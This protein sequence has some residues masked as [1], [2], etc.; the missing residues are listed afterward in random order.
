MSYTKEL[1]ADRKVRLLKMQAIVGDG[2]RSISAAE[3]TEFDR[4][5]GEI[6]SLDVK[7][8]HAKDN[9]P[10]GDYGGKRKRITVDDERFT[11]YLRG[12]TG[13]PEYRAALDGNSMSTAPNSGGVSAGATGYDA[14]YMVPQGFWNQL[15]IALKAYGGLSSSF[16]QVETQTGNPMPWPS[17]DP[18]AISGKYLTEVNQL[19]FGGDSAGTDYQF[20]QGMLNAWTIVSGVILASVQLIEDSAFDVD[21]FVS[22]RIGEAIGRK[23]ASEVYSGTGS[24]A[25]LGINTA[26]NARGN[27]G[28]SG[29]TIAATGGYVTLSAG[30]TVAVFGNYSSPTL[31]ELVGNVLS[32]TTLISMMTA[33]DPA[34]YPNARWYFNA[35]QAW[36]MRSITDA[37][38]RPILN[39]ANGLTADDVQNSDYTGASPVAQLFGFPV[40]IDNSIASLSASTTGGPIFGSLD[41]AMVL[42]VVRGDARVVTDTKPMVTPTTM[43]LTE[44]YADYLQVGYLGFLRVDSRSNDLRAA[45]T[46]KCAGT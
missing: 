24:S 36:A 22:D 26:L 16:R 39:F 32:P 34:Y 10:R 17:V 11:S 21:A 42:R 6:R 38:G 25:C 44:R 8:A 2:H 7:L 30:K 12:K 45:V 4:L 46:V 15:A 23:L 35:Q 41:K 29:S 40:V 18:T 20:G 13:A 37:N 5:E 27:A 28:T 9:T 14:G 1:K 33:V 3:R 43:K 19:G 31:T